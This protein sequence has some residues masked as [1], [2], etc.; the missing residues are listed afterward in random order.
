[1][2]EKTTDF[3]GNFVYEDGVI[4]WIIYDEGRIVYDGKGSYFLEVFLKDHL[5][6]VRVCAPLC[7]PL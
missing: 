5:G 3:V 7:H 1:M 2:I 6:N 4:A